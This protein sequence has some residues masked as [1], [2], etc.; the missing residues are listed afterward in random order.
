MRAPVAEKSRHEPRAGVTRRKCDGGMN[1]WK[2]PIVE[3]VRA[4]REDHAARFGHDFMAIYDDPKQTERQ[5]HRK[6]VCLGPKRLD[7]KGSAS[8]AGR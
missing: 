6:V 7:K 2:D 5:T 4:V 1:M 3:E 8:S